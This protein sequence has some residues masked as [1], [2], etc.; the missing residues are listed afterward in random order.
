MGQEA[1]LAH[2]ASQTPEWQREHAPNY[3][4][5]LAGTATGGMVQPKVASPGAT[6]GLGW[7]KI[8]RGGGQ[9]PES[10]LIAGI[11][12]APQ[13]PNPQTWENLAPS[14]QQAYRAQIESEGLPFEDFWEQRRRQIPRNNAY[15]GM[16]RPQPSY[17]RR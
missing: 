4:A 11:P 14:Q 7:L 8:A 12:G 2:I 9:I 5:T 16:F 10:R 17:I 3:Y 1:S 6:K 13:F 15:A